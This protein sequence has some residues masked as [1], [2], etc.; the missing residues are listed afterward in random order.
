MHAQLVA[1]ATDGLQRIQTP[2]P[3]GLQQGDAGFAVGLARHFLCS[4]KWF[5]RH[6]AAAVHARQRQA[7]QQWRHSVVGLVDLVVAKQRVVGVAVLGA[8][9]Q[10]HQ[11]RGFAV[12]A[13]QRHQIGA[14]GLALELHQQALLHIT[15]RGRDGHEV[16]FVGHQQVLVFE[17][18]VRLE[19]QDRLIGHVAVVVN[20]LA[21]VAALVGPGGLAVFLEHQALRQTLGPLSARNAGHALGQKIEQMRRPLRH[22]NHAGAHAIAHGQGSGLAQVRHVRRGGT[23]SPTRRGRA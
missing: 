11:A 21:H 19:R 23:P 14:I 10:Q 22:R 5:A 4:E 1:F 6:Q 13:V 15:A 17:H 8:F 18:G 20:A 9:A 7:R 12:D 3:F 16:R 2:C